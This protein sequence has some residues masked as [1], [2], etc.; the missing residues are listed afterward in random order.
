MLDG[1]ELEDLIEQRLLEEAARSWSMKQVRSQSQDV[2]RHRSEGARAPFKSAGSVPIDT[3]M[4]GTHFNQGTA[5][6]A[7]FRVTATRVRR[8]VI[9][10][11][12]MQADCYSGQHTG[13]ALRWR[14]LRPFSASSLRR[15]RSLGGGDPRD[16]AGFVCAKPVAESRGSLLVSQAIA[17]FLR[18]LVLSATENLSFRP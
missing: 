5:E 10:D 11:A 14:R 9:V 17:T 13:C 4:R 7:R 2:D 8:E 15:S 12:P 3:A 1:E 16:P 18:I 6:E